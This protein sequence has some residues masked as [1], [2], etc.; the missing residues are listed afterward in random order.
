MKLKNIKEVEAFRKVIHECEGDVY[1]KSP[2][3][4]V[5]NLKSSL[6]EYIALGRLLGEAGDSLE[7]F[8]SRREDE[9]RLIAFLNEMDQDELKRW[10]NTLRISASTRNKRKSLRRRNLMVPAAF[11]ARRIRFERALQGPM[12]SAAVR[13]EGAL[14]MRPAPCGYSSAHPRHTEVSWKI[15]GIATAAGRVRNA[16]PAYPAV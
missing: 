11:F 1:L 14:Q 4:D 16:R 9:A 7:L 10:M 15:H 8:A 13:D 5:F 3:G 12:P 2:E 6:S